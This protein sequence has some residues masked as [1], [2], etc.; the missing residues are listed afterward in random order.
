[1]RL[2]PATL[3]LTAG[4][5]FAQRPPAILID[6]YH[7][8]CQSENLT[9]Q[10]DF[11]ELQQRLEGEGVQVSFFGT[12][13]FANRPSIEDLGKALGATIQKLNAPQVDLVSHSMGGLIVRAYLSGKQ[14]ASGVFQPP[15]DTHVRKWVSIATPNFG[16][17]LPSLLTNFFPD[18][19]AQELSGGSQFL[20]DLATWNQNRDDLRGVDAVGLVGNAGGAGPLQGSSDGT[21]AVTSASMSFTEPDERTRVLPYCHGAGDLTSILGLGCNAP[22]LAKIQSDNPLS[23]S[24]IDS[25]LA[26]TDA[27]KTMG[28]TPLQDGY[29]RIFGGVLKQNRNSLDQPAGSPSD[30]PYDPSPP[31]RGGYTVV[32]DKPGPRIALICP[33]AA[34]VATLSLAPRMLISIYGAGLDASTVTVAGQTLSLGYNDDRQINTLLPANIGGLT[35]L[36]VSNA[37]GKQSVNIFVEDGSGTGPAA[38]I[39]TGN[40]ISLYLTGLGNRVTPAAVFLDGTGVEVT[41]SGPAPGYPGLDQIN[42]IL[43]VNVTSGTVV[44]VAGSHASNAVT[45]PN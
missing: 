24:I 37:Q 38:A 22:P 23:W 15:A 10:H 44:V 36:T 3:V 30:D 6:G 41:Y 9:S 8:L 18:Q 19:Q 45:L 21:V 31:M 26:G 12:C 39:P 35:Q 16:A 20:F 13:T 4:L 27:W 5:S 7:L 2:F 43:P 32:I 28:H 14:N 42:F 1:M 11:G 29:L 40:A 25:F 33:S 17:L 34:R